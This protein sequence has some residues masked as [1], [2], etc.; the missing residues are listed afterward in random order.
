ML[1]VKI[2]NSYEPPPLLDTHTRSQVDTGEW[3]S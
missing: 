3:G 1:F 2:V